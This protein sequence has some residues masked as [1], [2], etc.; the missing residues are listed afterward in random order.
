[1]KSGQ[2]SNRDLFAIVRVEVTLMNESGQPTGATPTSPTAKGSNLGAILLR[3][4]WLSVL[5]GLGM[6]ILLL[7]F[8]AGSGFIPGL[9]PIAAD[10]VQK[11][12]WSVLVCVGVAIGTAA[13]SVRAPL[14][15]IL[16]FFAAPAAFT[17][18]RTLHQGTAKAL[19]IAGDAYTGSFIFLLA[20]IKG[21]EYAF[22][23]T[24]VGWIGRRPWG[25]LVAHVA[26]GLAIGILFGGVVLALTYS[27]APEP[28]SAT[29]FI[30]QGIDEVIFPVGCSLVL[31]SAEALG[32]RVGN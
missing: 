20:L 13:T 9:G 32:K 25:G 14:M 22:L 23:G 3:A 6:E 24:A 1:L 30:S 15:G 19:E 11:I 2:P 29:D 5:L 7:L 16:G 31:F 12:S 17:V 26:V 8:A 21:L 10:L 27:S 18:A 4:A 28:L